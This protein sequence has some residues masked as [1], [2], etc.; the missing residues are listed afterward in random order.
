MES[1]RCKNV[2]TRLK[3]LDN[4]LADPLE[5]HI[6]QQEKGKFGLIEK[7]KT[8]YNVSGLKT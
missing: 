5:I 8:S 1:R 2:V 4:S 3:Y 6:E 7:G